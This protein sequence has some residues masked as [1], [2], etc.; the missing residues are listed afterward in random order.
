MQLEMSST[1]VM[2]SHIP[3][4]SFAS[5]QSLAHLWSL[6]SH[7]PAEI[8]AISRTPRHRAQAT[9]LEKSCQ[10]FVRVYN[11]ALSVIAMCVHNPNRSSFNIE[12]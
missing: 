2:C 1:K 11:E 4:I 7:N 5:T 10:L 3:T 6:A 9:K 12:S 8:K